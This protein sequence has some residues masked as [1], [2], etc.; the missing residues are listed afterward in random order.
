MMAGLPNAFAIDKDQLVQMVKLGLDDRAVI[1]A[2]D[3]SSQGELNLTKAEVGELRLQG[4]SETIIAHLEASGRVEGSAS[5]APA[6]S[7]DPAPAPGGTSLEPAPAPAGE[8]EEDRLEREA[9]ER[10]REEEIIKKAQELNQQQRDSEFREGQIKGAARKF[11][12]YERLLERNQNMEAAR[13]YLEFLELQPAENSME[14]YDARFGLAK[15]LYQQGILS[16]ASTPLLEVLLAG[17]DKPRFREAFQML[18]VL[19]REIGYAPP[20][21]EELTSVYVGDMNPD[22]RDE[23]HYYL[24]KFFF[25]YSRSDVAI[26]YLGRVSPNAPSYPE[27]LYMMGIAQLDEAVNDTAGALKNFQAAAQAAESNPSGN[28]EILQ[29]GLIALARTWYEV[30]LYDVALYYYQKIPSDSARNADATFEQAWTYF[31]K[32]DFRRALGTFHT[33][34][35]PYY[36]NWYFPDLFIMEAATYVNLCQFERAQIAMAEF[37]SRYLDKKPRLDAFLAETTNPTDYWTA[38]VTYQGQDGDTGIPAMFMNAVLKDLEFYNMYNEVRNLQREQAALRSNIGALG[39]FGQSV[40]D[41]VDEQLATKIES[42][43]ILVQQKFSELSQELTDWESQMLKLSIDIDSEEKNQLEQ[44]LRNPDWQPA[45]ASGGTAFL[46]VADDW[47]RWKFE[48]EYWIDEV[49][50]YR[51]SARTECV[52]Q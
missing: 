10:A 38:M 41:R 45:Q 34:H 19:T 37:Q 33:L 40:L 14:W 20:V 31:V 25:G 3:S 48:G 42:G 1:A 29:L 49:S 17:A 18:Q 28:E 11:P 22:F 47:Q 50:N 16:G 44:R 32:N 27:A 6:P 36:A 30:G 51:S 7:T 13:A 21:L 52:E 43:G 23:F 2:I 24:G 5:T 12:E 9:L 26:D 39:E 46:V 35:S 15:A 4:V 8:T